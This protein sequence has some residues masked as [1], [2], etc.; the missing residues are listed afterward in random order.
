[1]RFPSNR[2]YCSI[3]GEIVAYHTDIKNF[4]GCNATNELSARRRKRL[5]GI[6]QVL[7]GFM[8]IIARPCNVVKLDWNGIAIVALIAK[9]VVSSMAIVATSISSEIPIQRLKECEIFLWL[10]CPESP[11]NAKKNFKKSHEPVLSF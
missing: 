4:L 6:A 7:V 3:S 5:D 8:G 1:M 11:D 9:I 10:A 2:Q